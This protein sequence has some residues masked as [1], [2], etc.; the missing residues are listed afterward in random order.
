MPNKLP[1]NNDK[2]KKMEEI[3]IRITK[4]IEEFRELKRQ[5]NMLRFTERVNQLTVDVEKM[6]SQAKDYKTGESSSKGHDQWPEKLRSY[7]QCLN[8][9]PP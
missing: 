6:K 8:D 3:R 7:V 4:L 1:Y 9:P 5:D 2:L